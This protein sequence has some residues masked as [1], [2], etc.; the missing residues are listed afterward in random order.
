MLRRAARLPDALVGLAPDAPRRTRPAPARSA[1]AGAAGAGCAACAAGSSRAPRRRRRSGAGR[2]RRCRS[3]P[4][5]RRRSPMRSSRVVSVRSRRPSIPYM[6]CSAAVLVG[7]EVGDE[8]HE[9]VG[10]PVEVE[11]VQRLQRERRVAHPRVAV[12]PVA[13]AA[14]RLGQRRRERRDRRAGRHVREALDRQ[15]RAL[16]RQRASGGR[17]CARAGQPVAPEA[18]RR[19]EPRAAR[20]RRRPARRAPRPRRASSTACSPSREQ[21]PRADAVALDAPAPC[22]VCS[23]IV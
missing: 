19:V 11:V 7:L 5:A 2:R 4:A 22:P 23:R 15:R 6:I 18:R 13:L 9:L 10:L 12:V 16:D 17:G 3:G 8:L 1:T 20:R 21:M 14:G